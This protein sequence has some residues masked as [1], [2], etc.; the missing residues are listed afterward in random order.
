VHY[1]NHRLKSDGFRQFLAEKNM[2][3]VHVMGLLQDWR[4]YKNDPEWVAF[5]ADPA[6]F[7]FTSVALPWHEYLY[8]KTSIAERNPHLA[9]AP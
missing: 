5:L 3:I 4:T 1:V 6:S 8:V 9:L 2:G 7:G